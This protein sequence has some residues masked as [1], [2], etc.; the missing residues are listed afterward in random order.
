M[1]VDSLGSG[2]YFTHGRQYYFTV[3]DVRGEGLSARHSRK[4]LIQN[5]PKSQTNVNMTCD[6]SLVTELLPAKFDL[7]IIPV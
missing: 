4:L 2:F 1:V 3:K 5:L 7:S 6:S